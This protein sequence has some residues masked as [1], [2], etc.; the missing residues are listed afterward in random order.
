MRVAEMQASQAER[1]EEG[2]EDEEGACLE[3]ERVAEKSR[4][5]RALQEHFWSLMMA[6]LARLQE[7]H[8]FFGS[9][10]KVGALPPSPRL[11]AA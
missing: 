8:A 2:G 5:L 4:A 3:F 11:L 9:A 6:R 7:G 1:E 10:N